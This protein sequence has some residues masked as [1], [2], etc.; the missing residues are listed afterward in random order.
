MYKFL[1]TIPLVILFSCQQGTDTQ[2]VSKQDEEKFNQY[3]ETWRSFVAGFIAEDVD[4]Q[5]ELFADDLKWSQPVYNGNQISSKDD[6]R[7]VIE[8]WQKD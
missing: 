3:V 7:A 1:L 6:L 8:S 2:S 5:M 4:S